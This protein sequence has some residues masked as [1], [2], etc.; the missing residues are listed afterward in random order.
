MIELF[1]AACVVLGGAVQI[2]SDLR[3]DPT[4]MPLNPV[5]ITLL[6]ASAHV[7]LLAILIAGFW[8]FPWWA[9]LAGLVVVLVLGNALRGGR[10]MR[11]NPPPWMLAWTVIGIALA[12]SAFAV[13]RRPK[14]AAT[15]Y[16][17]L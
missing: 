1:L 6:S 9:P 11:N 8:W 2:A 17:R 7:A 12:V 10:H 5:P 13:Q 14:K 15:R 4:K 16:M 3:G